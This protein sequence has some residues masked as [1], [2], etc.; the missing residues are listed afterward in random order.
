M[1]KF[2]ELIEKNL[3]E[4]ILYKEYEGVKDFILFLKSKNITEINETNFSNLANEFGG[5]DLEFVARFW[6][7][8]ANELRTNGIKD[9]FIY[10]MS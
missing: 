1:L 5:L 6:D 3:N 7:S 10:R 2:K 9:N 8:F 4:F